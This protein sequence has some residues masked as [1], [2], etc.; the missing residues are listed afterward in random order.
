MQIGLWLEAPLVFKRLK[1]RK[2]AGDACLGIRLHL[3]GRN[4]V[5]WSAF[6]VTTTSEREM[7]QEWHLH[8]LCHRAW[9]SDSVSCSSGVSVRIWITS[10][11]RGKHQ[12]RIWFAKSV[13]GQEVWVLAE[14]H[15][16]EDYVSSEGNPYAEVQ[17]GTLALQEI[18]ASEGTLPWLLAAFFLCPAPTLLN[19][20]LVW[21]ADGTS[22]YLLPSDMWDGSLLW[23]EVPTVAYA[24][25]LFVFDSW[26]FVLQ[27]YILSLIDGQLLKRS[28]GHLLAWV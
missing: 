9:C 17:V 10:Q 23:E 12:G 19:R 14:S 24:Q 7:N 1:T 20:H 18:V 6:L 27:G 28:W 22:G 2:V 21:S 16:Q 13:L 3:V 15:C 5:F 26:N 8:T 4:E 25:L 11:G